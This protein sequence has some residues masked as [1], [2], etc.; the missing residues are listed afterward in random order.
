M[1]TAVDLLRVAA[2]QLG[3]NRWDDPAE[4]TKYGRDYGAR[5]GAYF[6]ASGVPYCDMF[7][8]WCLR[9]VGVTNFDS[10]YV[11][12]RINTA[13]ANGWLVS[14]A[15]AR[16]GDLVCFDWDGDGEADHIGIA[17]YFYDWSVQTIEGNTSSDAAGSQ[18]NGGGVYRRV[19]SRS[20]VAAII[21]PPLSG[22]GKPPISVR[23]LAVDGEIGPA[24]NAAWQ[25]CNGQKPDGIVSSQYR[26]NRQFLPACDFV[27]SG[28][29]W[30]GEDAQGSLLIE[31]VQK[32]LSKCGHKVEADGIAGPAFVRA[33]QRYYKV[34]VDGYLGATTAKALQRAINNQLFKRSA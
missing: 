17:E 7:V 28:W 1:G 13:R 8:T 14:W 15:N 27:G 4:G 30:E 9:Q 26:P 24:T 31:H 10:A 32:Y 34:P 20:D 12:G 23:L 16:P 21:R 2:S 25:V 29:Q 33:L 3:Y 5:H 18:S 22:A 19:R 6:G 11:P